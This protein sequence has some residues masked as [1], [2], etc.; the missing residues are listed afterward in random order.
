MS[1]IH[2]TRP[3]H[4]MAKIFGLLP[5]SVGTSPK[6]RLMYPNISVI[7]LIWFITILSVNFLMII[8]ICNSFRVAESQ[9]IDVMYAYTCLRM[10]LIYDLIFVAICGISNLINRFVIVQIIN[11]FSKIDKEVSDLKPDDRYIHI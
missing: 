10:I 9:K 5:F 3:I 6:R 4:I 1:F 8:L 11:E 7:D 2:S